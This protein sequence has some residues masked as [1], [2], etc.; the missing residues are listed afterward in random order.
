VRLPP[1]VCEALNQSQPDGIGHEHDDD[2]YCFRLLSNRRDGLRGSH[3]NH[4]WRQTDQFRRICLEERWI[5]RGKAV[6]D[7]DILALDP[8][9]APKRLRKR[10]HACLS[11]RVVLGPRHQYAN[12]ANPLGLLCVPGERP[13]RCS[14]EHGDERAPP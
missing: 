6:V 7:P 9:K 4:L 3:E 2:R 14:A 1:G 5:T 12:A 11:D 13:R 10:V 8:P